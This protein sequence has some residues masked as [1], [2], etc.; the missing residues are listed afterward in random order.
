LPRSAKALEGISGFS[1]V[2]PF[3]EAKVAA[4]TDD[5]SNI[6]GALVRNLLN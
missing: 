3:G 1:N 6:L 5:F 4:W 2:E